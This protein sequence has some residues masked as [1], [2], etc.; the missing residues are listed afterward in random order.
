MGPGQ[1]NTDKLLELKSKKNGIKFSKSQP[2]DKVINQLGPGQYDTNYHYKSLFDTKSGLMTG[3]LLKKEKETIPGPGQYEQKLVTLNKIG[4][5]FNKFQEHKK[6]NQIPGPGTYSLP[7]KDTH[8]FALNKAELNQRVSNVPGPGHY[9]IKLL[10]A[11]KGFHFNK[12]NLQ[13]KNSNLIGPGDYELPNTIPDV[14][15]YNYPPIEKRKIKIDS[16]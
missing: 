15:K 13:K 5:K 3:K 7:Q 11:S 6:E 2:H 16:K 4:G 12:S 9:E 10:N 14:P 1:Y 8:K